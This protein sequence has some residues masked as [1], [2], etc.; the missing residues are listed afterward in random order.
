MN[1]C[2][3]IKP[4]KKFIPFCNCFF[5]KNL[6]RKGF[7]I[8]RKK[9]KKKVQKKRTFMLPNITFLCLKGEIEKRGYKN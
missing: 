9:A 4:Q 1:V 6:Y 8:E 7:E 5:L 3:L 2:V